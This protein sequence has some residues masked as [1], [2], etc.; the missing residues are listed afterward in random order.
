MQLRLQRRAENEDTVTLGVRVT[1]EDRPLRFSYAT[2]NGALLRIDGEIAG[3]FDSKHGECRLAA[4]PGEREVTVEVERRALPVSG[5]P[6]GDG[7]AWRLMLARAAES[8]R[9]HLE[10]AYGDVSA[11][12]RGAVAMLS[13]GHAHL[14]I[15]WLWRYADTRRKALRTFA[16]AVR[17]IESS[18]YTFTQSQPQ[19]YSWVASDDPTLFARVRERIG[20]GFDANVA[21]MWVES[22]LHAPSG[23]SILRQF[24][25][26][27]RFAREV[28]GAD[29]SVVWLPDTFGFP[30]TLPQLAVHAGA[31]TFATT[32]LQWN[33]TTRWP[34]PQF[35]WRG[36][37]GSELCAAVIDAYGGEP[38]DARAHRARE[39]REPLVIGYGDGGGGATDGEIARIVPD[40]WTTIGAWLDGL[41]AGALPVHSGELY[42]ETHRG[43]YT[44]HRDVKSRNA[45]LERALDAAEEAVAWCVAVRAAPSVIRPLADDLRN[46]WTILL[47]NQFHDVIA[48]TSVGPVYADVHAEYDR[49]GRIAERVRE[50]A[51]SVLPRARFEP[52][53]RVACSPRIAGDGFVL[54]N[55]FVRAH[56]RADGT[57]DELAAIGG[58]NV[59]ALLNGLAAY[60]DKPKAWDAWNLDRTYADKRVEVKPQGATIED[61]AL[62]VRFAIGKRS[63]ATMQIALHAGE[64]YLSVELAVAW[65]EDHVVLRS[66]HRIAVAARDV[67]YG[68][69]H[70]TIVRT[71]YAQTPAERAKFEVPAQRW[72]LVDDGE[73]GCALLA[74]DTY[75]WNAHGLPGGGVRAGMSL[76]RSPRWPDPTADRGEHRIRYALAPTAGALPSA[77]EAAW[78]AYTTPA[79]VRLFETGE[80]NVLVVATKPA[81]DGRGVIV[82]VR[83]C[84]G[85]RTAVALRCGGRMRVVESTDACELP[86]AADVRIA[87]EELHFSLEP[88][89]LRSFRVEF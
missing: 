89:A 34:H 25:Y 6:S 84:D 45:A 85:V 3:A 48:G 75:G 72:M 13:T 8:P 70:G 37:D 10:L 33:D 76:L 26:G 73:R 23:E 86:A 83:E 57:V 18:A 42:L 31:R 61:G 27:M 71:A 21:T 36:D 59:A 16:T 30:N 50:G 80:P 32:K 87:G 20:R 67:R 54:E 68:Q 29:P 74:P 39:R 62:V 69:P 65:Y 52:E 82:R 63:R 53:S 5:L 1:L 9:D 88:F 79:R 58:P 17:Q 35:V 11:A 15:A 49:A 38:S 56:V 55:D 12:N 51:L 78:Q 66:E 28:L 77:L 46:A 44:T 43:T 81:D 40:R 2:R 19:L 47:R 22:D 41:D 14:D 64:P 4:H 60:A 7:I 24:A